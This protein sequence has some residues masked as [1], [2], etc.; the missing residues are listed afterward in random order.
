MEMK[1]A[2]SAHLKINSRDLP[3]ILGGTPVFEQSADAP[4]PKLGRME[5]NHRRRG[6]GCL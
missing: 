4:Y 3:A 6:A 1:R 2:K 5:T